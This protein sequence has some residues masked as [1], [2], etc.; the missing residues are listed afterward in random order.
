LIGKKYQSNGQTFVQFEKI[1]LKI[2]PGKSKVELKNLF[3]NNPTLEQV[4]NAFITENSQSFVGDTIP[5]LE[6]SLGEIFTKA[7]NEVIKNASWDEMF[8]DI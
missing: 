2:L 7:A 1:S 4:G 8:P 5:A 3:E 6:K